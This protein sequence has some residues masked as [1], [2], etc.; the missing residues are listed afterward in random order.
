MLDAKELREFL[1]YTSVS[2]ERLTA[3]NKEVADKTTQNC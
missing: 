1:F 3:N 2:I